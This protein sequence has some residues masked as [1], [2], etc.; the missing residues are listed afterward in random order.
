M[1]RSIEHLA[2]RTAAHTEERR[3]VRVLVN[4][5]MEGIREETVVPNLLF[6]YILKEGGMQRRLDSNQKYRKFK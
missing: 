2:I 1:N 3:K 5:A 6:V 4:N